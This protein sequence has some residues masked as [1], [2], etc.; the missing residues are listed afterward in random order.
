M[1]PE[2]DSNLISRIIV[3]LV[4]LLGLTGTLRILA[5]VYQDQSL[6]LPEQLLLGGMII[7]ALLGIIYVLHQKKEMRKQE[8]FRREKW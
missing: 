3:G 8:N 5:A 1:A 6:S 7:L 4:I 2:H